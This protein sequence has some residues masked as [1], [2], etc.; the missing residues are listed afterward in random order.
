[1]TYHNKSYHYKGLYVCVISQRLVLVWEL[2][3]AVFHLVTDALGST[4]T[5]FLLDL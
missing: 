3:C 1:M 4:S 5:P 2:D